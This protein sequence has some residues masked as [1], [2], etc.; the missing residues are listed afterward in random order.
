MEKPVEPS[1]VKQ[2]LT[3]WTNRAFRT[4][5]FIRYG[6]QVF[7]E[8]SRGDQEIWQRNATRGSHWR[9]NNERKI[10]VGHYAL[11]HVYIYIYIRVSPCLHP[12]KCLFYSSKRSS[13]SLSLF[14]TRSL[15]AASWMWQRNSGWRDEGKETRLILAR[16]TSTGTCF[17][18][19]LFLPRVYL[20]KIG[21]RFNGISL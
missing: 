13:L 20:E 15:P 10:K 17:E 21:R 2:P 18:S 6:I 3:W 12:S 5:T 16:L 7:I 9:N 14:S 19:K 8:F 11:V 4:G 1:I